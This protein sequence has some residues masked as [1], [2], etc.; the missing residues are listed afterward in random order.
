MSLAILVSSLNELQRSMKWVKKKR[1]DWFVRQWIAEGTGN[2]IRGEAQMRIPGRCI[3]PLKRGMQRM[4]MF[5]SNRK[6]HAYTVDTAMMIEVVHEWSIA[7]ETIGTHNFVS[8]VQ[9]TAAAEDH[10]SSLYISNGRIR[11]RMELAE[12][13]V[14]RKILEACNAVS[15]LAW[16]RVNQWPYVMF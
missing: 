10:T 14:L 2:S 15:L 11:Q 3:R 6:E 1:W 5:W 13:D 16:W 9:M 12:M 7:H 8:E 4:Q